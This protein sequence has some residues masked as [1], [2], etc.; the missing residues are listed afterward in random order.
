MDGMSLLD[1]LRGVMLDPAEQA[2]Y[3]AD[4]GAYLER[5]GYEGVDTAGLS[6]AFGLVADTL[7]PEQAQ[8]WEASTAADDVFGADTADFDSEPGAGDTGLVPSGPAL[9]QPDP[10]GHD[11][12]VDAPAEPALSFGE[13]GEAGAAD[14]DD[15]S[16][17]EAVVPGLD[18]LAATGHDDMDDIDDMADGV[19]GA[20]AGTGDDLG[21]GLDHDGPGDDLD[22]LDD[23]AELDELGGAGIGDVDIGSF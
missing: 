3:N 5:Y 15:L 1:V 10:A 6:E 19:G 16:F 11:A 23:V 2:A 7:T 14:L 20:L 22:D 12:G 21:G 13:G 17:D 8:A 9:D 4:P 18:G